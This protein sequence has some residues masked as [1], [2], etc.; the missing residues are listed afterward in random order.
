MKTNKEKEN[1]LIAAFMGLTYKTIVTTCN[2]SMD[3]HSSYDKEIIYSNLEPKLKK[4]DDK[5]I[6]QLIFFHLLKLYLLQLNDVL[7][8]H[9]VLV[10]SSIY[11]I[12]L[13]N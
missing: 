2:Y 1:E 13:N 8:V 7:H 5:F 9:N 6:Y 12:L 10:E 4:Y 3:F 11:Q